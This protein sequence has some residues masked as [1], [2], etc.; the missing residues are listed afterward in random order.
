MLLKCF[1]RLLTDDREKTYLT[2]AIAATATTLTI[3]GVDTNAWADNDYLIIGEIGS[4]TAEIMQANGTVADGTSLVI[5]RSGAAGGT[6]FAHAI[7]E[8]VYRTDYNRVEF[9]RNTTDSTSGV[10]VLTTIEV[11]PDD[12]FTRY[13]DTA[14][15]TGYGFVRF[16]NQTSSVF[17]SYSDGVNYEASGQA[18]SYDPRTLWSMRKKVRNLLDE[19]FPSSKLSDQKI[20]A[21]LND[22]QRDVAHQRLWSFYEVERSF[23]A[24]A[25]ESVYTIPATVQKIYAV[26]FRTQT[27]AAINKTKYDLLHWDQSPTQRTPTHFCIWNGQLLLYP[28]PST[29]AVTT[30]INQGGGISATATSVTVTSSSSFLRGEK[31]RFIIESEVIVAGLSTTTTFTVLTRAMEGTTGATHA[32]AATITERDIVYTGHV[33]PADLLDIS[34]RTAVP[35]PDVLAY[36]AAIDLAPFVSKQDRVPLFEAKYERKVKELESKYAV[37]QTSQFGRIKSAAEMSQSFNSLQNPNW[38]PRDLSG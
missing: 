2:A 8:P 13:E 23:S 30:T 9:N 24:V 18:S 37:K 35:E 20:D 34:D 17:S 15:T 14:N 6:R 25:N 32:N 29:A 12:E 3:A 10:S 36:G 7:G 4:P 16:N 22:K 31:F 28:R 38:F 1:N 27:L 19:D 11:Q 5:D 21:A 33:E 26:R